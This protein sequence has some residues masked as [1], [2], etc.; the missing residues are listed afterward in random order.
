[1]RAE[2]RPFNNNRSSENDLCYEQA[3]VRRRLLRNSRLIDN[4]GED[5]EDEEYQASDD[6]Q[7]EGADGFA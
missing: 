1:M 6:E 7:P 4:V 3:S 5:E 2:K